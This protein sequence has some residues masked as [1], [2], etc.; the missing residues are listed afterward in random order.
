MEQ[1]SVRAG[2]RAWRKCRKKKNRFSYLKWS[3][4]LSVE[5]RS[6]VA[7]GS[8]ATAGKLKEVCHICFP[9]QVYVH[10]SLRAVKLSVATAKQRPVR[11]CPVS[12]SWI[13]FIWFSCRITEP[14]L[15]GGRPRRGSTCVCALLSSSL[16]H[17]INEEIH[18]CIASR[19]LEMQILMGFILKV[20]ISYAASVAVTDVFRLISVTSSR[21]WQ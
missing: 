9:L 15:D 1:S 6:L 11:S 13:V 19:R 20:C 5:K 7:S 17:V 21:W 12:S 16:R 18:S 4:L 14:D 8:G 3:H 10:K 2:R